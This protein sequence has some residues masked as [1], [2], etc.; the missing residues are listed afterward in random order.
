MWRSGC[1]DRGLS[2]HLPIL[3]IQ[4]SPGMK[5]HTSYLTSRPHTL[6]PTLPTLPP[7]QTWSQDEENK[8]LF[9]VQFKIDNL[10]ARNLRQLNQLYTEITKIEKLISERDNN[11]S[12]G[13]LHDDTRQRDRRESD[14]PRVSQ[15]VMATME[16][17]IAVL[18]IACN[19]ETY[20]KQTLD[21][22]LK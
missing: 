14:P 2:T 13:R 4:C 8:L 21:R 18:V 6:L 1:V 12:H 16:P 5:S 19:R 15:D 17:S 20:I 7:S 9:E 11:C 22:L 3:L 10:D